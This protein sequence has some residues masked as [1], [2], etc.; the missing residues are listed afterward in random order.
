MRPFCLIDGHACPVPAGEPRVTLTRA[1][2]ARLVREV[3]PLILTGRGRQLVAQARASGQAQLP[4][5]WGWRS[6]GAERVLLSGMLD[7]ARAELHPAHAT[8]P[9]RLTP[10]ATLAEASARVI[11]LWPLGLLSPTWFDS[12]VLGGAPPTQHAVLPVADALARLVAAASDG[13]LSISAECFGPGGPW[14]GLALAPAAALR[15]AP[16]RLPMSLG[17]LLSSLRRLLALGTW[18]EGSTLHLAP[19]SVC[20]G[21][22]VI[23]TLDARSA[24]LHD[25]PAED[26]A[27]GRIDFGFNYARSVASQLPLLHGPHRA[28][29]ADAPADSTRDLR[30]PWLAD[31]AAL[32]WLRTHP[33]NPELVEA[34]TPLD[35]TVAVIDRVWAPHAAAGGA[36]AWQQQRGVVPALA[37]ASAGVGAECARAARA[38]GATL[39][40]RRAAGA[41]RPITAA[42]PHRRRSARAHRSQLHPCWAALC[43]THAGAQHRGP[44]HRCLAIQRARAQ[45][46]ARPRA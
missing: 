44:A 42:E 38:L 5:V 14:H 22:S 19:L 34:P 41:A 16:A 32:E 1:D 46:H 12:P 33:A 15:G 9:I 36:P 26:F 30:L 10:E 35:G 45:R 7:L 17:E 6:A 24:P 3:E 40:R 23:A 43:R 31:P 25:A 27:F 2:G 21:E 13:T 28:R 29:V 11:D 4:V 37:R 39:G 8:A 20:Y 18:L